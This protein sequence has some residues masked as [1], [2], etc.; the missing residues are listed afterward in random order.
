VRRLLPVESRA[1]HRPE[2]NEY[3]LEDPTERILAASEVEGLA[4]WVNEGHI[5]WE[6]DVQSGF[7]NAPK[8]LLR[9]YDGANL[10]IKL[11]E[12]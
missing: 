11:L 8:G 5:T 12:I 6:A 3:I 9:L 7:E 4:K 10:G 1:L 2:F